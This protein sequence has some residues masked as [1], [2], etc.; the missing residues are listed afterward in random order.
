M[1]ELGDLPVP[2]IFDETLLDEPQALAAADSWLRRLA[3][4]GARIRQE[5]AAA[6]PIIAELARRAERG[7]LTR[8]RALVVAGTDARLLR[9]V[10]EPWCPVPLVAWPSAGLPG[11]TGPLDLVV[12]LDPTGGT[13]DE[14][15][16]VDE[17]RR[18]GCELVLV[19]PADQP[20]A[21]LAHGRGVTLVPAQTGDALASA[22][23]ALQTVHWYGVGAGVEAE[24]VAGD[25]DEVAIR[26]APDQESATNPAKQLALSLADAVP[27][28]WGGSVLAARAAR[29]V[30]EALRGASGRPAL[31]AD[32]RHLLPVLRAVSP[33]DPFADPFADALPLERRPVLV[34]LDDGLTSAAAVVQRRRLETL[35]RDRGVRIAEV[36]HVDRRARGGP[37]PA[38]VARYASLQAQGTWAAAYLA[39]GLGRLTPGTGE[40][41]VEPQDRQWSSS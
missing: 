25:L 7:D 16:T 29:R 41:P 17:A 2:D 10:L 6:E 32:A 36:H 22:V 23:V 3:G 15:A 26:C 40:P 28:L 30:A 18:R 11:W 9:A 8:P 35:G 20:P 37:E 27:L 13:E 14:I 24:D 5:A 19:A 38:P 39:V 21:T 31:A 4:A 1:A 33:I 12:V 34:V